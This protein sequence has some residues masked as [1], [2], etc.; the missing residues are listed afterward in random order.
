VCIDRAAG[1]NEALLC[2]LS[3]LEPLR[4]DALVVVPADLPLLEADD[5]DAII[6]AGQAT[7]FA[8]APDR[9][10]AGTNALYLRLPRTIEF[11]FGPG[12]FARHVAAGR[13]RGHEPAVVRRPGLSSDIDTPADLALLQAGAA[14]DRGKVA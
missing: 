2:A 4:H 11:R 6:R 10:G 9:T 3:Q 1:L 5:L 14:R 12:S 7:G 8:I 13:L